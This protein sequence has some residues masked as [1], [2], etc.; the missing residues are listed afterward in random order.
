VE[1]LHA[2]DELAAL[3]IDDEDSDAATT[4]L[5]GFGEAGPEVGLIDDGKGLLNIAGLGHGNN[6]AILKVK[7]TVLL[8]DR[9]QHGLNDDGRAGVGDE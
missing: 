6:G 3:V 2:D 9:T 8:E 7:D 4:C 5:E 1:D